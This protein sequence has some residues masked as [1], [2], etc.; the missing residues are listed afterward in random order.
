MIT[1]S[2]IGYMPKRNTLLASGVTA[3]AFSTIALGL[4]LGYLQYHKYDPPYHVKNPSRHEVE[5]VDRRTLAVYREFDVS[6]PDITVLLERSLIS[7][8]PEF[9][10]VVQVPD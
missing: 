1:S 7:F 6:Q 9:V 4:V 10:T 2:G 5:L 8:G 3:A